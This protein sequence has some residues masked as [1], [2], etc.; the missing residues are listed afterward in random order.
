V[1]WD[2][3]DATGVET[4]NVVS[5]AYVVASSS[6]IPVDDP[7]AK[8]IESH[9]LRSLSQNRF[10]NGTLQKTI[11][12]NSHGTTLG[13]P[14]RDYEPNESDYGFFGSTSFG[15]FY[16]ERFELGAH[17][18]APQTIIAMADPGQAPCVVGQTYNLQAAY[19]G[20]TRGGAR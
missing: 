3:N 14:L 7:T 11:R 18:E 1:G 12:A 19:S 20:L 8:T 10:S 6:P 15:T 5:D 17:L 16:I 2:Q 13:F 4:F 9:W